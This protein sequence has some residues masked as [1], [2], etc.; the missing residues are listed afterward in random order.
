MP[1][2]GVVLLERKRPITGARG[3][4]P[5][6][7]VEDHRRVL[8][9]GQRG[10][11]RLDERNDGEVVVVLGPAGQAHPHDVHRCADFFQRKPGCQAQHGMPSIGGHHQARANFDRWNGSVLYGDY[12]AQPLLGIFNRQQG[13]LGTGQLKLDANWV[14]LGGA[15]YNIFAGRFDQTRVGLGYVDD[16]LIMGLNYITNYT[17]SGNVQANHMVTLQIT[18]RTLGGTSVSQGVGLGRPTPAN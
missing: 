5:P 11:G 17:F 10:Q 6:E 8:L 1:A 4:R 14:L 9:P 3:E 12:A 16:C 13:I 15:R 18:L 2:D 7:G